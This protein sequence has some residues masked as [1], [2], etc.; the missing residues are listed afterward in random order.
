MQALHWYNY[1]TMIKIMD[2][3]AQSNKFVVLVIII[4][5]VEMNFE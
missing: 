2:P 4:L 1:V 3:L 5:L